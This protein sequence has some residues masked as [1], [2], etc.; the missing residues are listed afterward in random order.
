M[1]FPT[2]FFSVE[3]CLYC[4]IFINRMK[5]VIFNVEYS[6][7]YFL[8]EPSTNILLG[9]KI[10]PFQGC[11][12]GCMSLYKSEYIML[13]WWSHEKSFCARSIITFKAQFKIWHP[14]ESLHQQ[15]LFDRLKNYQRSNF[16][17]FFYWFFR[18]NKKKT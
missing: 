18:D 8:I 5:K 2:I 17:F 14:L 7:V 1:I 9:G 6:Y 11:I 12:K 16:M 3:F 13:V 10:T 15:I 4:W